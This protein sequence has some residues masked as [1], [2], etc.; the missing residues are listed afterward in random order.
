MPALS[1]SGSLKPPSNTIV[2]PAD[3]LVGTRFMGGLPILAVLSMQ[4]WFV[5]GLVEREK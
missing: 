4:R 1:G 2:N 3:T 5:K